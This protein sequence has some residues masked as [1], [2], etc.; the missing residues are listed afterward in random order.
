MQDPDQENDFDLA[1]ESSRSSS[2]SYKPKPG[3]EQ[4]NILR[5]MYAYWQQHPDQPTVSKGSINEQLYNW[6]LYKV[7]GWNRIG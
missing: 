1:S 3:C 7:T 2:K 5:A 4:F 6:K